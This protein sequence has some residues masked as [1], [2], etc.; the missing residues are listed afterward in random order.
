LFDSNEWADR[1][2]VKSNSNKFKTTFVGEHTTYLTL[3]ERLNTFVV[4]LLNEK[5]IKFT[6]LSIHCGGRHFQVLCEIF[7][8]PQIPKTVQLLTGKNSAKCNA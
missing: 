7:T 1:Q 5:K 8:L 2:T 4:I 3:T 6:A